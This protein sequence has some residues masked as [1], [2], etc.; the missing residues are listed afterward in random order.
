MQYATS[1]RV[2]A[3]LPV[4][5]SKSGNSLSPV[6]VSEGI[7]EII[8]QLFKPYSICVVT[9]NVNASRSAISDVNNRTHPKRFHPHYSSVAE[10][11]E[12]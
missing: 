7:V 2:Q 6:I 3:N 11:T 4:V 5:R 10:F 12:V 1:G 9:H 8:E